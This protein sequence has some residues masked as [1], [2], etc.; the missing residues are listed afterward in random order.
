M[1]LISLLCV[2]FQCPVFLVFLDCIHQLLR[3]FPAMFQFSQFYL[4][5]VWDSLC[6][7][8]FANFLFNSPRD[9]EYSRRDLGRTRS[10]MSVWEWS[11]QFTKDDT[12]LFCNP[13]YTVRT[14]VG[15]SLLQGPSQTPSPSVPSGPSLEQTQFI[16]GIYSRKLNGLFT[17]N[18][19]NTAQALLPVCSTAALHF[20]SHCFLRWLTPVQILAG[21]SPV[22][23]V[24]QSI[25]S[26]EIYQLQKQIK[27]L[28]ATGDDTDRLSA[29]LVSFSVK[30][31]PQRSTSR[32]L[33]SQ[34]SSSF[35]FSPARPQ[36]QTSFFGTPMKMVLDASLA[37]DEES[38]ESTS[39]LE[40]SSSF[41]G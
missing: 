32:R 16:N 9:L 2:L 8:L 23:Y 18:S 41:S 36:T 38:P 25:L 35:P 13:L 19:S 30:S 26:E 5:T 21:G 7:G 15:L 33:T 37:A 24:Q 29:E 6:S 34:L 31:N 10:L 39:E 22:E 27:D 3:Q 1:V 40:E 11:R 4:T 28:E 12:D 14:D 17:T 20:W